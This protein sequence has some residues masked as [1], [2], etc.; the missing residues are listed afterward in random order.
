MPLTHSTAPALLIAQLRDK[1][2]ETTMIKRLMMLA[3]ALALTAGSAL[4][5]SGAS[6]QGANP[7]FVRSQPADEMLGRLFIGAIV[8]NASGETV[9]DIN[10]VVFNSS[11]QISTVVLGVGGILGMGEKNVGVPFNSLRF[12]KGKDGAR[13]ITILVSKDALK[14]AEAFKATEKTTF[15]LVK[16]KAA[17]MGTTASQKAGELKDQAVK[18]VDEMRK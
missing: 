6:A 5:P 16:D 4:L 8:K 7:A 14:D 18:K 13:L 3:S 10:D 1:P 2:K 12:E 15:D 9:G 11:G 17:E